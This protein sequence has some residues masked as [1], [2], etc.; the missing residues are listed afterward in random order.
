MEYVKDYTKNFINIRTLR[1]IQDGEEIVAY[2]SD[3]YFDGMECLCNVCRGKS[4]AH[5]V[6]NSGV[7]VSSNDA[8]DNADDPT[9]ATMVDAHD[10]SI[11]DALADVVSSKDEDMM[12]HSVCQTPDDDENDAM[13]THDDVHAMMLF[14]SNRAMF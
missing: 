10:D 11:A 2:Y 14:S 5:S 3:N 6:V 7:E 8:D 13:E 1:D 9:V 12:S 4:V